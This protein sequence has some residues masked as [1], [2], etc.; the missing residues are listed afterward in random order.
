MNLKISFII[1]NYNT[2]ALTVRC[3]NSVKRFSDFDYEIIVVDNGSADE[4]VSGLKSSFADVKVIENSENIG[5]AGACN[6]GFN[7]SEGALVCF[8][9][10]DAELSSSIKPLVKFMRA[11]NS[12]AVCGARLINPDGS[13]QNSF[14]KTPD[15]ITEI[16]N[17]SLLKKVFPE[18]YEGKAFLRKEPFE[19]ETLIG[20]FMLVKREAFDDLGGFDERYFFFFEESDFC[21]R[22]RENGLKIFIFPGVNVLHLQGK[23][24]GEALL[25]ARIEYYISRYSYFDKY[26]GFSGK[27]LLCF[28]LGFLL[29]VRSMLY[30]ILNI[31]TVFAVREFKQKL[32]MSSGILIWHFF[33]L[34]KN[35]GI[36][37]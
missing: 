32:V 3:I 31:I 5:F 33:G 26:Y 10:S 34:R 27:I 18:K 16:I 17:K 7:K 37:K 23:S 24:A 14:G 19:V 15:F 9:N 25:K 22:V 28:A 1:I 12:A 4:S 8:L 11:D 30:F 29:F 36:D 6:K 21:R 35:W 2:L 20:A 13:E